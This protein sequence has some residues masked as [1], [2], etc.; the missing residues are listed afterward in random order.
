MRHFQDTFEKH[1]SSFINLHDCTFNIS[2]PHTRACAYQGVR[3]IRFSD[4]FKGIKREHW[5]EIG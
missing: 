3:N 2:Y 5:D 4:L 1:K